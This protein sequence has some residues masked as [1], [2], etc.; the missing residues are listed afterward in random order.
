[1]NACIREAV[2]AD[3]GA[4]VAIYNAA[5]PG[6][7]ATADTEPVTVD[8]RRTWFEARDPDRRPIRVLEL[9]GEVQGWISLKSFY[10]GR[11]AYDA[12]AEVSLYL[13][14]A[15]QGQGWGGRLLDGLIADAPRLGVEVLLGF[16]FAHNAPSQRLFRRRGFVAVGCLPAIA[17]LDGIP[18]DLV[19]LQ[20][21]LVGLQPT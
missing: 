6:R 3:L 5:I 7:L 21:T 11:P 1:V 4:I 13:A 9:A 17:R 15:V 12:T 16:L 14:P 10:E 19:I 20:R 8:S 18:R 2:A